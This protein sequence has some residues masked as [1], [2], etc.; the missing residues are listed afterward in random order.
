MKIVKQ[1]GRDDWKL[2]SLAWSNDGSKL[3]AGTVA[4]SSSVFVWNMNAASERMGFPLP[5]NRSEIS[6]IAFVGNDL[7]IAGSNARLAAWYT[8]TGALSQS[9][10]RV[11]GSRGE[12][13]GLCRLASN[14]VAVGIGLGGIE[15]WY[16][17]DGVIIHRRTMRVNMEVRHLSASSDGK[18]ILIAGSRGE[19]AIVRTWIIDKPGIQDTY[20]FE[21]G[22]AV[23]AVAFGPGKDEFTCACEDGSLRIM[24]FR[25]GQLVNVVEGHTGSVLSIS[26][27]RTKEFA[28]SNATDDTIRLWRT[29]VWKQVALLSETNHKDSRAGNVAFN[30]KID[31]IL[32]TASSSTKRVQVWQ[33][34][35]DK[36]RSVVS[37]VRTVY[38]TSARIALVGDSGVGKTGLGYRIAEGSFQPT[39]ST[40]GQQFWVLKQLSMQRSDGVNCETVLWDFAGQPN[41]RPVHALFLDDIDLA[42][43]LFDPARQDTYGSIEYWLAQ[44]SHNDNPPKSVLVAARTD[45]SKMTIS[46]EELEQ[47]CHEHDIS[48][49]FI[50]TSAKSNEGVDLLLALIRSQ[51][52]WDRKPATITT[53]TFKQIK[54]RVLKLKSRANQK[55]ILLSPKELRSR[56]L[57]NRR[58][59]DFTNAELMTAVRHLQ[60]HGYLNI[61]RVSSE[62]EA[63]LIAPDVLINLA[64]SFFLKAQTNEKGLGALDEAKALSNEYS[65]P[66]VAKLNSEDQKTLL[67]AVTEMFLK[68]NICFRESID[69]RAFLI[70]PSQILERPPQMS[71]TI[72]LVEDAT[73]VI[74][75]AIENVYAAMV[76]LLGYSPTFQ[77]TNQWH[78]QAQYETVRGEVCG[79]KLVSENNKELEL[80]IYYG[81]DTPQFV[82]SRFQGLFEEILYGRNVSVK[83]FLPVYCSSCRRVLERRIVISRYLE[84]KDFVFCSD[85]GTKISLAGVSERISLDDPHIIEVARE[86][87]FG[88]MRT[89]YEAAL[90]RVKSV[91]RDRANVRSPSCFISYAW[92]NREQEKWVGDL[93]VNLRNA[94]IK[95][96]L[97]QT[98]NSEIGASIS[99]YIAQINTADFVIVVGTP[100]YLKKYE[101]RD[102]QYGFKVATEVD[103]INNRLMGTEAAKKTVLPALL[104]GDERHSFPPLV[105]GRIYTDFTQRQE[106]F[107]GLFDLI[108][109][110][111]RI[112]TSDPLV[113][114][115]RIR[116]RSEAYTLE[117]I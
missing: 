24:N 107:A 109:T 14:A 39:E 79:F 81:K 41:F 89:T 67:N 56:L 58:D 25:T 65:F 95:V 72:E 103:L 22:D 49:G 4:G 71:T 11:R 7:I 90:V 52:D 21:G 97:D 66:E 26:F 99:R 31:Q 115:L 73:Y 91:V 69:G 50:A 43:I 6:D 10:D 23:N 63:I 104:T 42:L 80:V 110:I 87:E 114:D 44:L 92:G 111:Y 17:K 30:P 82:R 5:Q 100:D 20:L 78:N 38:Y 108:L 101:N 37:N 57:Q 102:P 13:G 85:D 93:A 88:L 51:I 116:I 54:E 29:D 34:D 9:V 33:L 112:P 12:S 62:Q 16:F 106:Y 2:G 77:R 15:I 117:D 36:L 74:S 70:F 46:Q 76:V 96:L 94:G 3:A 19:D 45:V 86:Q 47:F 40:H 113:R 75:G 1:Y 55:Q 98:D 105:Q 60:N 35:Y 8:A 59:L 61:I 27:S 68:R 84:G 18:N 83:K 64:S 53:E 32:A 28:A 48:G